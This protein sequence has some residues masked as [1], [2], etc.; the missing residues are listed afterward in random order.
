MA[1]L[2]SFIVFNA[3]HLQIWVLEEMKL[4][5]VSLSSEIKSKKIL[6]KSPWEVLQMPAGTGSVFS[7]LASNKIL[8]TL[9]AMCIEYV[10]V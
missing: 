7:S 1:K 2:S 6:L 5:V 9:N 3:I 8:D 10:Q 4:P